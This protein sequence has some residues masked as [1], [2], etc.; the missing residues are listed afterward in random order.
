MGTKCSIWMIRMK[1]AERT[2]QERHVRATKSLKL[3]HFGSLVLSQLANCQ[4]SEP[5][6][7]TL[8]TRVLV[9]EKRWEI[10]G[11]IKILACS[12][13]IRSDSNSR[14]L[15]FRGSSRPPTRASLYPIWPHYRR[16]EGVP[17]DLPFPSR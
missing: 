13:P 10:R 17:T 6:E 7:G 2:E 1:P 11:L 12:K 4:P 3:N 8:R 14:G 16:S 15:T 5:D 9:E